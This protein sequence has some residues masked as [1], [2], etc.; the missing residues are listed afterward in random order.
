MRTEFV[1]IVIILLR[2]F[3]NN[4]D[5]IPAQNILFMLL[6]LGVV[7]YFYYKWADDSKELAYATLRMA[8]QLV[9]IATL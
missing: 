8:I 1:H 2:V 9:L 6:P 7:G 3:G 5:L 4:M